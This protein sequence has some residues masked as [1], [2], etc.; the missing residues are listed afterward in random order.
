MKILR[1]SITLLAITLGW[2]CISIPI[3]A[4]TTYYFDGIEKEVGD[5]GVV[6][7]KEYAPAGGA[8]AVF[9]A[10]SRQPTTESLYYLYSDHVGS[11]VLVT[12]SNGNK[13]EEYQ[14][15]PYGNQLSVISSQ[16]SDRLYT[17]QKKDALTDLY[18]YN[19]RYYNPAT[20][21]FISADKAEGPNRYAYVGNNP[22]MRNDPSGKVMAEGIIAE[23]TGGGEG[24]T[25][26]YVLPYHVVMAEPISDAETFGYLLM[27]FDMLVTQGDL[28]ALL[29]GFDIFTGEVSQSNRLWGLAGLALPIPGK[30]LHGT[31]RLVVRAGLDAVEN[32]S[33][34]NRAARD[35]VQASR[36]TSIVADG[37][38]AL[39]EGVNVA[40]QLNAWFDYLIKKQVNLVRDTS[41]YTNA[42]NLIRTVGNDMLIHSSVW[43][44]IN[45]GEKWAEEE[46]L[47]HG[48]H[49]YYAIVAE[50]F[51][52]G[53]RN[54]SPQGFGTF[55][56]LADYYF[57][58]FAFGQTNTGTLE[59]LERAAQ[60]A[61]KE[62]GVTIQK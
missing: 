17:G 25:S 61:Y 47:N 50:R 34:V 32:Y 14:Y 8:V 45:N 20:A 39:D 7:T 53:D 4:S 12:D 37:L 42:N 26:T 29:T 44:G 56:H 1:I 60:T 48:L 31:G 58:R 5:D 40:P 2:L 23:G 22:V 35:F 59:R 51:I 33:A 18:F 49:D 16:I 55:I 11:T 21:H 43:D 10:D 36:S 19:A 54:V 46:V 38:K 24:L 3:H 9:V 13:V 41:G 28:T 6:V 52:S 57:S 15:Y 27:P 30:A 62:F